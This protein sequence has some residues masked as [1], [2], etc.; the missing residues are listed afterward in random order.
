MLKTLERIKS[1]TAA[2]IKPGDRI[3]IRDR[4]QRRIQVTAVNQEAVERG[5]FLINV[6]V[7]PSRGKPIN[8]YPSTLCYLLG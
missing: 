5:T 8:L 7:T 3:E 4:D 2:E 1:M 6:V